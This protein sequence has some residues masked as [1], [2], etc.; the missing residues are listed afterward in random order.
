MNLD[1]KNDELR[2]AQQ[3]VD[4]QRSELDQAFTRLGERVSSQVQ[5]AKTSIGHARGNAFYNLGLFAICGFMLGS[6]FGESQRERGAPDFPGKQ[7]EPPA[8]ELPPHLKSL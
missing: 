1:S 6:W 2:E 8:G 3:E 7:D 4:R 5:R